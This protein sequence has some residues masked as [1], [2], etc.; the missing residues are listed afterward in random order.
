[1][2]PSPSRKNDTEC[3]NKEQKADCCRDSLLVNISEKEQILALCDHVWEFD[4]CHHNNLT[5]L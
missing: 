3:R 5:F 4:H 1:M 2:E